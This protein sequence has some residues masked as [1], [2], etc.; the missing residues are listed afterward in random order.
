MNELIGMDN[1][2][3]QKRIDFFYNSY[4]WLSSIF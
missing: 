2:N 4:K 1:G 3:A